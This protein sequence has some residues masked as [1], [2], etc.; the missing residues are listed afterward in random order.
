MKKCIANY[1]ILWNISIVLILIAG[2]TSAKDASYLHHLALHHDQQYKDDLGA[3]LERRYIRVLTTFNKTN[4][5]ISGGNKFGFEYSL[6]KEY[7]KYLNKDFKRR[8]LKLVMEFIPVSRDRLLPD[9]AEGYGDIAAASLTITPERKKMVNF[10]DPY[11]KGVDQIVVAHKG[12]KGLKVI[13]DLSGR[14][15]YV[16]KSSSYFESLTEL[17]EHFRK[18]RHKPVKIVPTDENLETEDILELVNSGAIDITVADSYLAEIWKKVF[19]GIRVY[20]NIKV[21]SGTKISWAVRKDNPELKKSLNEFIKKHGRGTLLGNIYFN[22][23][24]KKTKWIKNPLDSKEK[25]KL[26]RYR[27]LFKKY[28]SKYGF[29]WMLIAAL[30]YQESGLDNNKKNPS[31]AVGV[32]QVLPQTAA[33]RNVRINNVHEVENNIHA[34]VKYL[35]FL[36]DRY[37][38][39]SEM[40]DR[41]RIRFALAAY[42]AGPAKIR[43]S[44]TAAREMGLDPDKWFRNVE[45]AVLKTIGQETVRYVSSINKYYL[46]FRSAYEKELIRGE[47]KKKLID[48]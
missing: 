44:R 6:L 39:S 20:E 30:A 24:Y 14:K 9:L 46:L 41:D 17:N 12:V 34:G 23:Y 33:D 35:A 32:M 4:F 18:K 8:D 45:M 40:R 37:F 25:E 48:R 7:E 1:L 3:I 13:E 27:R 2:S 29:D 11:I 47:E 15:V 42:N 38:N 10:T 19:D 22:R 36:R 31:G 43:R 16:R 28:S 21:R 5:F 26:E